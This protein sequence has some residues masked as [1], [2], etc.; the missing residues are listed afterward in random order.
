MQC[1]CTILSSV[2]CSVVHY[3]FTLS[4]KRHD[5]RKKNF[6]N[7]VCFVFSILLFEIF[8]ILRRV[9]RDVIK[10][11]HWSSY[12]VL[13]FQRNLNF[14][15]RVLKNTKISVWNK[16]PTICHFV[17]SFIT[18]LQV[19]QHVSDNHVPIFRSWRL[20]SVIATCWYCAVAAG[21][22]SEPVSSRYCVH[23]G[24]RSTTSCATHQHVAITLHSRQLL[25]MDTLLPETCWASS[26]GVIK[27]N[28]KWHLVSFLF[29][30]EL[31][32]T[33]NHTSDLLKYQFSWK[34][35]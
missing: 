4:H 9:E 27:D 35:F 17:L 6:E 12:K 23:W 24:V 30:T 28:T 29:H 14:L 5:F 20:R 25:K 10:N 3:S 26:I 13:R 16:K 15:K 33:V 34:S 22:L 19:A 31:R 11:V 2:A 8:L 1:V 7:N 32:C 21:R 18:P